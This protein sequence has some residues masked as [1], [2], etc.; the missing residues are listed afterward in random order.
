MEPSPAYA[1]MQRKLKRHG[2]RLN[3]LHAT[4]RTLTIE[5]RNMMRERE[6]R[7]VRFVAMLGGVPQPDLVAMT[8][9][10]QPT[11]WRLLDSM[12]RAG[13]VRAVR[14]YPHHL[15][16]ARPTWI[17]PPGSPDLDADR[18][19]AII[20]TIELIREY[21]PFWQ[22]EEGRKRMASQGVYLP[23]WEPPTD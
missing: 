4:F 10:T 19:A 12:K 2:V 22:A 6:Q 15:P 7:I 5:G 23:P 21:I 16:G 14:T 3:T 1:A 20:E 17:Q 11:L 18:R 8:G 13:V 9:L